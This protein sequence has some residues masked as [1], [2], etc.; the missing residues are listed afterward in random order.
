MLYEL[1]ICRPNDFETTLVNDS[2]I[3]IFSEA[4]INTVSG[5]INSCKLKLQRVEQEM[6]IKDVKNKIQE[7]MNKNVNT[8]MKNPKIKKR[9][10]IVEDMQDSRLTKKTSGG[11]ETLSDQMS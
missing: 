8:M 11:N 5:L 7:M 9:V 2:E 3:L 6:Q 4:K 10:T 1:I